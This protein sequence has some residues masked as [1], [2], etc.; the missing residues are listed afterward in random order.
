MKK[1]TSYESACK[2]LKLNPKKLPIV[3]G[4][5]QEH[6]KALI[7]HYKLVIIVQALNDGWKPDWRN[8]GQCKYYPYFYIDGG[9]KGTSGF[10]FS[11]TD[12]VWTYTGTYGS[13]R[14][15][16]KT[17]ELAEYAGKKFIKLYKE[18]ILIEK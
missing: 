15:C 8:P 13:S 12:Y 17:R 14:L 16:F 7:A 10:G 3:T 18:Y 1:I 9:K 2:A 4:L 5:P 11:A 6:Q